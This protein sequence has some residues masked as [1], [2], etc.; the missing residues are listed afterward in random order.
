METRS[1]N[2]CTMG[3][4]G[5]ALWVKGDELRMIR[6]IAATKAAERLM[7]GINLQN[8]FVSLPPSSPSM[9]CSDDT[10]TNQRYKR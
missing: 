3:S 9:S 8:L 4:S 10:E 5:A 1:E 6:R 2:T 7:F